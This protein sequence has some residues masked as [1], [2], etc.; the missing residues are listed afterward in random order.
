MWK[1]KYVLFDCDGV[2]VDSETLTQNL[3]SR[4]LSAY[5]LE[6]APDQVGRL[7]LGGTMAGVMKTAR[8]MGADLP[9]DWLET[10]LDPSAL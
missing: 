7:F 3:L 1:A 8:D 2:L 5:G 6:I 10:G 9:D 4:E